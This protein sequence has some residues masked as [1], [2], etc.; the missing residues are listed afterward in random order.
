MA[1]RDAAPAPVADAGPSPSSSESEPVDEPASAPQYP[2]MQDVPQRVALVNG[3]FEEPKVTSGYENRLPDASQPGTVSVP[4]WHTTASDHLIEIWHQRSGTQAAHGEQ[5]AELNA[6]EASTLYQDLETTPGTTLYWSLQ[7]RGRSG[8]DT[9]SVKIGRPGRE[10]DKTWT[11]TD[12]TDAWG[13]HTGVYKVPAGQTATRFAFEAG[14]TATGDPTVGNF[15]DDIVF[16]SAPCVVATMTAHPETGAAVGDTITYTINLKNHGGVPAENLIL[17]D[18]IPGGTGYVPGSLKIADEPGSLDNGRFDPQTGRLTVPL[19][20]GASADHGG[21]LPSTVDLP[22]GVTVEFQVRV[23]RDGAGRTL[24]NQATAT[25]TNT[26]ATSVNED[27]TDAESL[28]CTSNAA[29]TSTVPDAPVDTETDPGPD[30]GAAVPADTEAG[31][32]A[33][34]AS[35]VTGT[36]CGH[37]VQHCVSRQL[38]AGAPVHVVVVPVDSERTGQGVGPPGPGA[39]VTVPAGSVACAPGCPGRQLRWAPPG[40][41]PAVPAGIA[42]LDFLPSGKKRKKRK[43]HKRLIRELACQVSELSRQVTQLHNRP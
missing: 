13:R 3:S 16:G 7:H 26:S 25:Y 22:D 20:R 18:A 19:G 41:Q 10:P 40:A 34:D 43:H 11:F 9:M 6:N 14:A 28:T 1:T 12:G 42:S 30:S 27:Q 39:C 35:A 23:E 31:T 17:R 4:G 36:V 15:L 21:A 29:T 38:A 33:D 2:A 32:Q 24:T 37:P 8:R 5:W